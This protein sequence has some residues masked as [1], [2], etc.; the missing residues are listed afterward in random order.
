MLFE[1]EIMKT[2]ESYHLYSVVPKEGFELGGRYIKN[3][4]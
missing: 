3:K 2:E 1:R 4:N